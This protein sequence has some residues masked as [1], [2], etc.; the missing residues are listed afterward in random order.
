[1]SVLF[2][3]VVPPKTGLAVE[4]EAGQLLRVI[5]LEGQQVVDM[6]VFNKA[7]LREK[8]SDVVFAPRYMPEARRGLR[9]AR[10]AL[11]GDS[12]DR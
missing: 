5:D 6:A 3:Q 10:Q 12:L 7:N 8:L 4:V 9:A 1:M 11:Q 2:E